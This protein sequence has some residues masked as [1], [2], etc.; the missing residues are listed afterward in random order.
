[1]IENNEALGTLAALIETS[2]TITII[3]ARYAL[4][5]FCICISLKLEKAR[6][7]LGYAICL[8]LCGWQAIDVIS[9]FLVFHAKLLSIKIEKIIA[10]IT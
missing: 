4:S 9:F 1:M 3:Q 5:I 7:T 8:L 10:S 6:F 2:T